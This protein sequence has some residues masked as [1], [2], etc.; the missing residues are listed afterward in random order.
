MSKWYLNKMGYYNHGKVIEN[1]L[2]GNR[3][4]RLRKVLGIVPFGGPKKTFAKPIET[5]FELSLT[6][7]PSFHE[8][9]G[10]GLK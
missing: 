2:S 8:G 5:F 1:T 10:Y 4:R 7:A 6:A 3:R 9:R